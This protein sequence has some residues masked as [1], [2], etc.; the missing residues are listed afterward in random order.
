MKFTVEL[1]T[2]LPPET[3]AFLLQAVIEE[4][5]RKRNLGLAPPVLVKPARQRKS[6][7][8][9]RQTGETAL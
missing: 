7:L 3:A 1:D 9:N 4:A 8:I 2:S 6:G 5:I